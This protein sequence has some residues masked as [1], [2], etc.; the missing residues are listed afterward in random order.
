ML[1]QVKRLR[2]ID[3]LRSFAIL[4]MLQGHFVSTFLGDSFRINNDLFYLIWK[5]CRGFTAPVFFTITGF[6]FMFLLFKNPQKG[7][8]N[9]RVAKGI[10]RGFELI[11]WGYLLRLNLFGLMKG[12]LYPA[13]FQTDVLHII[14]VSL[15]ILIG[16]YL[17]LNKL[18]SQIFQFLLIGLA[19][20]IFILEPLYKG[21]VLD[22][23]PIFSSYFSQANGAVFYVFPWLGYCLLGASFAVF[24]NNTYQKL[25]S[26][27]PYAFASIAIGLW[28]IFGSATLLESMF[29]VF[30]FQLLDMVAENNHR[31]IRLGNTL[32]LFG[33]FMLLEKQFKPS[34]FL[35]IGQRTLSV[36][37]IHYFVLYGTWF[38]LGLNRLIPHNLST[39]QSISGALL[40]IAV[41]CA[42]VLSYYKY[43]YSIE[44][45]FRKYIQ[46]KIR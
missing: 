12:K 14:G 1:H 20:T 37:I 13:F 34:I 15:L 44:K 28:L 23:H 29:E 41:V 3:A 11:I 8:N 5:Y 7:I 43:G 9:P 6:I 45:K 31:F 24:F 17:L 22:V 4:M 25:T 38:G 19:L 46:E 36:Y 2:F 27:L 40:F 35:E 18:S 10:K 26:L 39:F 32:V 42:L 21:V 16:L 33:V 30:Q